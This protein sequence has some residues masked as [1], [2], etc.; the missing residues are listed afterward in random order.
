M[1]KYKDYL[2][3][4]P[5]ASYWMLYDSGCLIYDIDDAE[6]KV[7]IANSVS[8]KISGFRKNKIY[9]DMEGEPYFNHFCRKI[10]FNECL[11]IV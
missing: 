5:I 6:E 9:Y 4:E 7:L 3:K 2:K 10:Y 11:R 1:S 8:G